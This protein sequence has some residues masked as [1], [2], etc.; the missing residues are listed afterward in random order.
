MRDDRLR[1]AGGLA[2]AASAELFEAQSVRSRADTVAAAPR[3]YDAGKKVNGR[4]R[5]IVTDTLGL[6]MLVAVTTASVQDRDG[7]WMILERLRFMM[8]SIVTVFADRG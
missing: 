1:D 7:C 8:P 6:L 2:P 5:H 4:K 3:G